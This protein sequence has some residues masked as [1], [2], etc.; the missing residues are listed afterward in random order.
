MARPSLSNAECEALWD[1]FL[2]HYPLDRLAT[3]TKEEYAA[4]KDREPFTYW[5]EKKTEGLGSIWGGSAFKF[6]IFRRKDLKPKESGEAFSYSANYGWISKLGKTEDQAFEAVLK[7][8]VTVATAAA[9]GDLEAVDRVEG[10]WPV[11]KWKIAFLYQDRSKRI[12]LPIYIRSHLMACL[13]ERD[14]SV[15]ESALHT[16]LMAREKD[17][18]GDFFGLAHRLWKEA[19]AR[20]GDEDS[21][22]TVDLPLDSGSAAASDSL[23]Q[24][25]TIFYGPPGTGKT[26]QSVATAVE[27]ID[28]IFYAVHAEDDRAAIK[29]R[30]DELL[31]QHRVRLVTF[32]QTYGYEDFIEGI[33]A[34]ANLA[35]E[36]RYVVEAGIFKNLCS[37]AASKQVSGS[38]EGFE[39]KNQA[40]WKMSLGNTYIEDEDVFAECI[41]EGKV[42]LGWGGGTD[43]SGATDLKSIREKIKETDPGQSEFS[44]TATDQFINWMKKG[45][46]IIVTEGN[47]RF[48][49]IGELV[50]D[51][52]YERRNDGL[53]YTQKRKMRW[54][55]VYNPSLGF[56]QVSSVRFS[57][58]TIYQ[59]RGIDRAKLAAL[60]VEKKGKETDESKSPYVLIIDEINRGNI[61]RIFG[62][63]ITLIEDGKRA[64]QAE[65]LSIELPNSRE[66]FSVPSNVYVIGTMNTADRSLTGLDIALRRRF[67]FQE[68]GP[69]PSLLRAF[70]IEGIPLDELLQALNARIEQALDREHCIGH[71]YFMKLEGKGLPELARVFDKNILPLLQEYFFEDIERIKFILGETDR[72]DET[73]FFVALPDLPGFQV[74][75]RRWRLNKE[76]LLK[77][78]AYLK[79]LP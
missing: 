26:Y 40:V 42:L 22:P 58:M 48:R 18:L 29:G 64:G 2:G 13:G 28:P 35:G 10:L 61:S 67:D 7:L 4:L 24:L 55:R 65:A 32:H 38:N 8:V 70:D 6:G 79:I 77:A 14:R 20:L 12:I 21:E 39:L 1:S 60:L 66:S 33:K 78:E 47:L 37:D 53:S 5:V 73:C 50:G 63:V 76:A 41:A 44:A 17:Q 9:K 11:Y 23:H 59:P 25:N 45:D 16:R 69:N 56:E 31:A 3:L 49:A 19:N 30:F 68:I 51:Y 36:L 52:E 71:S 75:R 46:L 74:A 57:Q 27:I 54:L 34:S 43:F 72:S 62:E 15:P